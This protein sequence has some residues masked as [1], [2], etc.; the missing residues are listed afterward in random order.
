MPVDI[1]TLEGSWR[2]KVAHVPGGTQVIMAAMLTVV[3]LLAAGCT[4][5]CAAGWS[6]H[7]P[8]TA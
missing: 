6:K 2:Q 5:V 4:V 3:G 1:D 8:A 7:L